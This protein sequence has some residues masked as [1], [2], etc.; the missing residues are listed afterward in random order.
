MHHF[1]P[2][3]RMPSRKFRIYR[4]VAAATSVLFTANIFFLSL[5]SGP[6]AFGLQAANINFQLEVCP[7]T[8]CVT[9]TPTPTPT[10]SE[11][12][13]PTTAV[14]GLAF[15]GLVVTPNTQEVIFVRP[16][17]GITPYV[18]VVSVSGQ[19]ARPGEVLRTYSREPV[20]VGETNLSYATLYLEFSGFEKK[21]YTVFADS[22]GQWEFFSPMHFEPGEVVLSMTAV[23]LVNPGFLA[24]GEFRFEVVTI[25]PQIPTPEYPE[26]KKASPK[27]FETPV[28]A[29]EPVPQLL[30]VPPKALRRQGALPLVFFPPT[31]LDATQELFSVD[32]TVLPISKIVDSSEFVD[33]TGTVMLV[34]QKISEGDALALH[35]SVLS[36]R[37]GTIFEKED[38]VLIQKELKV[39]KRLVLPFTIEP[40]TYRII[41]EVPRGDRTY[42]SSDTFEVRER[43]LVSLPGVTLTTGQVSDVL[44]RASIILFAIIVVFLSLLF[45]EHHKALQERKLTEK[46]LYRDKDII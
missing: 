39:K 43:V 40:G 10:P 7:T 36:P 2:S 46:D 6:R 4:I 41:L 44:A 26:E 38:R 28:P 18:R 5:L 31:I 3:L 17:E 13:A 37:G 14:P 12:T 21:L 11:T 1:S 16:E 23:S 33:F 29:P 22:Q 9:P 35:Y 15:P 34:S 20:F 19:R 32:L 27:Y 25:P 24:H 42:I 45:W 30:P 8:G